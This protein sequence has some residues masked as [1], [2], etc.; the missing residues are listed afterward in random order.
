MTVTETQIEYATFWEV[1]TDAGWVKMERNHGVNRAYAD[2]HRAS[3]LQL[4]QEA[5][6]PYVRDIKPVK[7]RQ[8]LITQG[9]WEDA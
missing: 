6:T 5:K 9:D 4:A 3:L 1:N 8:V 2:Q 7:K